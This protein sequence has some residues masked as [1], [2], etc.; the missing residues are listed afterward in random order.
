MLK[1]S[2]IVACSIGIAVD[3]AILLGIGVSVGLA[4]VG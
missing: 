1:V 3:C 4:L 2:F